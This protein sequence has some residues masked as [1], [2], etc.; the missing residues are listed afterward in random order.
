MKTEVPLLPTLL[1]SI[2]ISHLYYT[3]CSEGKWLRH[4]ASL[5]SVEISDCRRLGS[6]PEEG[7]P[8]SLS[9]LT[10]KRGVVPELASKKG[11]PETFMLFLLHAQAISEVY[12]L[13]GYP[14]PS[15][16][17]MS[18]FPLSKTKRFVSDRVVYRKLLACNVIQTIL[19]RLKFPS[20]CINVQPTYKFVAPTTKHAFGESSRAT[21][22]QLL[23][24]ADMLEPIATG[25]TS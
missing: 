3:K 15:N 19:F 13:A 23:F 8:S 5:E 25:M 7:M 14:V 10:I 1:V 17:L 22:Y 24:L 6:L 20:I 2:R 18:S 21:K 16:R 11:R 12:V 4:L 9:V